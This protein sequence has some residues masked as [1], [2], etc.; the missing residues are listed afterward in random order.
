VLL[1]KELEDTG[2][3]EFGD[4]FPVGPGKGVEGVAA[5]ERTVGNQ[6]MQVRVEVKVVAKGLNGDDHT[7]LAVGCSKAGANHVA[8]AL[9]RR[10]AQ[11]RQQVAV[12]LKAFAQ[13]L[14]DGDHDLSVGHFPHDLVP[15]KLPELLHFLLV[16]TR[17]E[18]SLLAAEGDQVIVSAMI[19]MQPGEAAAQVAADRE[20]VQRLADFR[21]EISVPL[22]EP[23]LVVPLKFFSVLRQALPQRR[24]PGTARTVE[25][26]RHPLRMPA[27]PLPAKLWAYQKLGS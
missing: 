22:L 23:R 9:P 21:A 18:V 7:G 19:A 8:Q 3:Q 2:L 13:P 14:R 15:D 6:D 27:P 16:A 1:D 4:S 26:D 17:A 25:G 11:I 5:D 24:G 12:K 20:G 10:L